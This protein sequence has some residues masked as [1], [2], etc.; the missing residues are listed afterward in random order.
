MSIFICIY[1]CKLLKGNNE[2]SFIFAPWHTVY[3]RSCPLDIHGWNRDGEETRHSE[4]RL[5]GFHHEVAF[6]W[7][8]ILL[9]WHF[10]SWRAGECVA[11]IPECPSQSTSPLSQEVPQPQTEPCLSS[12][13]SQ[14]WTLKLWGVNLA[15]TSVRSK[16]QWVP[17]K[18]PLRCWG[19]S[20]LGWGESES[21][22]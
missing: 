18:V 13:G 10:R 2:V 1:L 4:P 21:S 5:L 19:S 6:W 7:L 8:T 17:A 15:L 22:L 12:G 3:H 16:S 11:R 9:A 14:Y 20:Q